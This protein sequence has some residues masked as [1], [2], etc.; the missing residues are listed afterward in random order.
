[1]TAALLAM[2]R[3]EL[4]SDDLVMSMIRE[5]ANCLRCHGG[6]LLDG[7]PRT[8]RQAQSL[9][10]LLDEL[11]VSLDAVLSYELNL[12]EI[13]ERLSGRRTCSECKSVFHVIS[14]QPAQDGVCDHCGGA[15]LQRDD[16]RP[17]A[18]RVRLDAYAEA[19]RPLNEFYA[20]RRKLVPISAQGSPNEIFRTTMVRLGQHLDVPV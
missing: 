13:V 2:R 4:V 19:T 10:A 6:F 17:H 20:A 5:R 18:I 1:M 3:G 11:D 8:L 7:I 9:E 16:D 14:R 15:L 12:E